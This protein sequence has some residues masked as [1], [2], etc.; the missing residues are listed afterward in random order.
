[1]R[2]SALR[3]PFVPGANLFLEWRRCCT[4]NSGAELHR[5]N[6]ILFSSLPGLTRQSMGRAGLLRLTGLFD[7][8]HVS[9]DHRVKP[10]GDEL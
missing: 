5:E 9:M 8:L 10:G 4:Q 3:L 2:L 7:S 1:M 6:D